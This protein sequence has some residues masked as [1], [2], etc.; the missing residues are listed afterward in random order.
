MESANTKL[1]NVWYAVTAFAVMSIVVACL[2]MKNYDKHLTDDV[3]RKLRGNHHQPDHNE[4]YQN[5]A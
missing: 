5:E 1:S 4:K 3:A 2:T